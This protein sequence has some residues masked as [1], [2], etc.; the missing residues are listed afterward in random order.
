MSTGSSQIEFEYYYSKYSMPI[1]VESLKFTHKELVI[2][3]REKD[4]LDS[5]S[6]RLD[7]TPEL[8]NLQ[9][10]F[11]YVAGG[12]EFNEKQCQI[13]EQ[14]YGLKEWRVSCKEI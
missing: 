4:D 6:I 11:T 1:A 12:K 10:V 3:L 13:E 14:T 7:L 2:K 8:I 9:G 5:N